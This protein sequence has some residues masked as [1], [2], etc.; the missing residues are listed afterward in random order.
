MG[1]NDRREGVEALRRQLAARL[2]ED[3]WQQVDTTAL[4]VKHPSRVRGP[5]AWA[6]PGD[7]AAGFGWDAAHGE[8]CSGFRLAVRTDLG[9][10]LVRA[11]GIVPAAV[12]ERPVADALL[13][14]ADVGGLLIPA[15]AG[16]HRG[17]VGQAWATGHRERGVRVALTP[18]R[19]DRRR[20]SQA[21]RRP[22]AALR[23]RVETTVGELTERL[24]LAR[25]GAKTVWGLL[26]R[27]AATILAH[28][29]TRLGYI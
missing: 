16:A 14:G 10:R 6:G 9:S 26:T 17:F 15:G 20:L 25:H 28:T 1:G 3:A 12:D 8:W 7:L 27:A 2:P 29:L 21:A 18:S 5:D 13:E 24:G 19:A 11:W 4:P 23:N 22:V